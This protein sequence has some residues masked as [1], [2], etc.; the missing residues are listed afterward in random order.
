[1][2]RRLRTRT[3]AGDTPDWILPQ[4]KE[5]H[6]GSEQRNHRKFRRAGAADDGGDSDASWRG[7]KNGERGAGN[8]VRD[9]E[10]RGGGYACDSVVAAIGPDETGRPEEDR[11]RL[12]EGD[13]KRKMD[14]V[15]APIN[16]AWAARLRCAQTAMHRL[17]PGTALLFARQ[18]GLAEFRRLRLAVR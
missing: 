4:K 2:R 11:R 5:V 13:S 16:L 9:C 15:F 12:D 6:H 10:R 18:D 1:M 14:H 17:Q 8:G 7:A 3:R